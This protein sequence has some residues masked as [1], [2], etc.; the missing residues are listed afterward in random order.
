[1]VF[2]ATGSSLHNAIIGTATPNLYGWVT[3]WDSTKVA[4]GDY[5]IQAILVSSDGTRIFSPP[6][7]I[8]VENKPGA[9]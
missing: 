2:Q 7:G 1:V 3:V 8:H 4:N 9:S 5:H 6:V